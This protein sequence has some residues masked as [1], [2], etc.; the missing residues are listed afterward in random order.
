MRL[1]PKVREEQILAAAL[2]LAEV[3]GYTRVTRE[4]VATLAKVS[5]ALISVRMGTMIEFRRALMR[6]AVRCACLPV[7]AQ[8]LSARDP[9]ARKAPHALKQRA[10]ATLC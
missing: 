8:G 6:Y 5:P 9:H 2:A 1:K 10:L 3:V 4:T 7:I